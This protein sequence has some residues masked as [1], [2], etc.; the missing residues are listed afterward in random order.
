[1]ETVGNCL[2]KEIFVEN[3]RTNLSELC[4]SEEWCLRENEIA[5]LKRTEKAVIRAM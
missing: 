1:M 2:M 4:G 3:E 5:I